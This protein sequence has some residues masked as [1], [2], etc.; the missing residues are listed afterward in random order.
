MFLVPLL[1]P[2]KRRVKLLPT[3]DGFLFPSLAL[4]VPLC[5]MLHTAN[6]AENECVLNNE[7]GYLVVVLCHRNK[8]SEEN[9]SVFEM[10][11]HL[12]VSPFINLT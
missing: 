9:H 11:K 1:A 2:L 10:I 3:T 7:A 5:A 8:R 12:Q 4:S 6:N